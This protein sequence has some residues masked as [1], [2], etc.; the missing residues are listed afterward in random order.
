ML[1]RRLLAALAVASLFAI[2]CGKPDPINE[3]HQGRLE[4]GDSTHPSDNSFFDEYSFKAGEGY[5]ITVNMT[6]TEV[7]P[8]L[9]LRGPDGTDIQQHDDIEPGTNLNARITMAA[10]A[11]GEYT[12]L[13]NSAAQGE[14]GAYTVTI[15]TTAPAN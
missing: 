6:S 3:T 5:T 15:Q 4:A 2:G 1:N 12:V 10:P 8:Y 7:D 13:A 9:H 14:T 11:T